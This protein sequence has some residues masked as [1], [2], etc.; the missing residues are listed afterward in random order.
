MTSPSRVTHTARVALILYAAALSTLTHWPRLRVESPDIP[1][2][3]LFAHLG[4]YGLLGFIAGTA[5]PFG[6]ITRA[7]PA[8][9]TLAALLIYAAIDESTQAIPALGRFASL[10]D[11]AANALGL[12]LGLAAAAFTQHATR[13]RGATA[14]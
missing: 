13:P 12:T 5:A 9:L 8:A 2:L 14:P 3:D 11:Y 7:R 1:R 4:A 10:D 6:R